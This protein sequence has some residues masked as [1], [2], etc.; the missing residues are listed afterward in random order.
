M[1]PSTALSNGSDYHAG[2]NTA[3]CVHPFILHRLKEKPEGPC[4]DILQMEFNSVA[5]NHD[6][7]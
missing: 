3:V 7:Y 6:K 1:L 4:A 2:T 5:Q